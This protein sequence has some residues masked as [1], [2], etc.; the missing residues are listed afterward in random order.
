M[1]MLFPKFTHMF[2]KASKQELHK[3]QFTFFFSQVVAPL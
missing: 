1:T 3:I 2:I